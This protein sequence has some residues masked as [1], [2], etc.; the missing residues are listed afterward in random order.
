MSTLLMRYLAKK[1]RSDLKERM[2]FLGGPRQVGKTTLAQSFL[3][4]FKDNHPAYL[5]W[6]NPVHAQ[7]IRNREWPIAEKL[8]VLDEIHKFKNWRNLVKGFYDTLKNTH[9]FLITGSARL[10]H[11]RKGGDSLLGRYYYYRLHPYTLSEVG[12][13][14]ANLTRLF[15]Y[16]GFPESFHKA[17]KRFLRR[18]HLERVNKLIRSD[19]RDLEYV[20]DINKMQLLAEE[21]PRRVGSPLSFKSLAEDLQIDFKTC[22]RWIEILDSLYYS[23]L[24]PPFGSPKIRAVKKEQKLYLWDYSQVEDLG[25]RF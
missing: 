24:I 23:F 11:F 14:K 20:S 15:T 4:N 9:S 18:W 1:I 17:D 21:L 25:Q 16:G 13:T 12:N 3:S 5:N 8:I 19:L 2:V 6:D 7:K 22:K 10:D